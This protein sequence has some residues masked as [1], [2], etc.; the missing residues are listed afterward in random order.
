MTLQEVHALSEGRRYQEYERKITVERLS[1]EEARIVLRNIDRHDVATENDRE[2]AVDRILEEVWQICVNPRE[3]GH[4]GPL[5][6]GIPVDEWLACCGQV[7]T[8]TKLSRPGDF[9]VLVGTAIPK[10]R[11]FAPTVGEPLDIIDHI[12]TGFLTRPVIP[13]GG[14]FALQAAEKP[15]C[16]RMVQAIPL[17]AHPALDTMCSQQA[18]VGMAGVLRATVTLVHQATGWLATTPC[19][20]QRPRH[21]WGIT[22][23]AH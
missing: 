10:G 19:H 13:F 18:P 20:L 4:Q 1:K 17:S 3:V 22:R 16:D 7:K 11:M 23:I 9:F 6:E 14:P 21:Q 12:L 8:D 5:Y 2:Q 15:L